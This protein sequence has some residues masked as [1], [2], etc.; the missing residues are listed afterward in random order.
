[1]F[2]P[3]RR[4]R[5]PLASVSLDLDNEWS[6][7]KTHGDA[8]WSSF[9]SY[10]DVVVPRVLDF[11]SERNLRITFFIVGQDAALEGNVG[12]LRSLADA[13]HESA[14]TRSITNPG[15][16]A[17]QTRRSNARL[18]WPRN[19]LSAQPASVRSAFAVQVLA[20]RPRC[21]KHYAAAD[22]VTTLRPSPLAAAHLRVH[23]TL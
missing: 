10:L 22:T 15:F 8:S 3:D 2:Q 4:A 17:T 6:Y 9:P 19:T 16:N 18:R 12:A 11:L 1:V 5:K 13:G 7:L 20:F 14:I 21:C 23:T